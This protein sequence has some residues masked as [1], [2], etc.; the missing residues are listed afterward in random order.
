MANQVEQ[1]GRNLRAVR[2]DKG[3][4]QEELAEKAGLTS[5]QISRVERG[6]RE[7]RLTTLLRLTA[8]LGTTPARLFD[9]L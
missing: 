8:A 1:F 2:E 5:V 9:G 3:W 4:T 7:V 6:V